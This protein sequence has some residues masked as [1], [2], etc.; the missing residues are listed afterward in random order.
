LAR[1]LDKT[2]DRESLRGGVDPCD[3]KMCDKEQIGLYRGSINQPVRWLK[4]NLKADGFDRGQRHCEIVVHH[5]L[6]LESGA[7]LIGRL[8]QTPT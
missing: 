6:F 3:A 4:S 7:T 8:R 1:A 5:A 2:A